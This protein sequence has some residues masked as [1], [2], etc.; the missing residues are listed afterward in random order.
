[1]P[2]GN[3]WMKGRRETYL[4]RQICWCPP[5]GICQGGKLIKSSPPGVRKRLICCKRRYFSEI[6]SITSW[7]S[8]MSNA[9]SNC[10]IWKISEAMKVAGSLSSWK[11][12]RACRMRFSDKSMPVTRQPMRAKGTRFPPRHNR[13]QESGFGEW[14]KWIG[15]CREGNEVHW[16]LPVPESKSFCFRV[17]AAYVWL[18]FRFIFKENPWKK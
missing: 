5:K 7:I 18:C 10:M 2:A 16:S 9:S 3:K 1:M 17:F 11:N 13:F 14:Q 12:W 4:F 15:E 8:M 6:C